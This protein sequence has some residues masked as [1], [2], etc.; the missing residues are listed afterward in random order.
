[1]PAHI[2]ARRAMNLGAFSLGAGG[3]VVPVAFFVTRTKD[4][5]IGQTYSADPGPG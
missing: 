2:G 3:G 5:S 4:G 1:M